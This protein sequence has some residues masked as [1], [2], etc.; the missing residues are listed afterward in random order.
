MTGSESKNGQQRALLFRKSEGGHFDS[1]SWTK[2]IRRGKNSTRKEEGEQENRVQ[3][4]TKVLIHHD[5]GIL[6][7]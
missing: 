2:G 7:K 3:R 5:K 6:F 4:R 1:K